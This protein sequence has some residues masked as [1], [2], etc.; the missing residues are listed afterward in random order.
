MRTSDSRPAQATVRREPCP[1]PETRLANH[2]LG[3]APSAGAARCPGHRRCALRV[4]CRL[5]GRLHWRLELSRS[6]PPFLPE[7]EWTTLPNLH[8]A[9]RLTYAGCKRRRPADVG[10][11]LKGIGQ[12]EQGRFAVG[13]P[14]ERD[15]DRQAEHKSGRDRDAG[16]PRH[17]GG[18]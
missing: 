3:R 4:S 8:D 16:I 10:R 13:P 14:E 12:L 6:V 18:R 17:R 15:A 1:S 9:T 11:L 2:R 5:L 7:V